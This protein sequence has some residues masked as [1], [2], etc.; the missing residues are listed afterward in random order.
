MVVCMTRWLT[1]CLSPIEE[2]AQVCRTENHDRRQDRQRPTAGAAWLSIDEG[3]NFGKIDPS[4]LAVLKSDRVGIKVCP[5][6]SFFVFN[7]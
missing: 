7:C 2:S 5:S 4:S 1:W 6:A 3:R